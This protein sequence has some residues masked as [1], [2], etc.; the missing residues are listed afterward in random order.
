[1]FVERHA[2]TGDVVLMVNHLRADKTVKDV[3]F[4]VRAGEVVGFSGLVGAG[5][6][7]TMRA[8]F[9]IDPADEGEIIY[10]GEKYQFKNPR[11]AI[12]RGFGMVSEDRK[13]EGLLLFQSIRINSTMTAIKKVSR[14]GILQHRREKN[15][16]KELLASLQAKYGS[17]EDDARSLSGG[18]QQKIAL[19][20]WIFADC[21][22][23]VFDEP[24]RGVDVGAKIEIYK[25]MNQLAEKGVA[26]IMV[27]SEMPEIIGMCDRVYVMRQGIIA[28]ELAKEELNENALIKLAMGV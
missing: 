7:E 8:I 11:D 25:I 10:F 6:T 13:K 16:V 15:Q 17:M 21:R 2:K 4:Y 14:G 19:A 9:G 20:K 18:N 3:S 27:S 12:G 28:G 26:V 5:R 22:C 24:T 1:M 23:I